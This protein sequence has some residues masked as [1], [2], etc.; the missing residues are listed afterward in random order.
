MEITNVSSLL[1]MQQDVAKSTTEVTGE[2]FK[3]ALAS[4]IENNDDKQLKASC[5]EMEAYMLSMMFKQMKECML[6]D[7]D[8]DAL[9]PKGDY[10]R[11]FESTMIDTIA[12][13]MVEAGGLG[14]SDQMYKQIKNTYGAQM[15]MSAANEQTVASTLMKI[16]KES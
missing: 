10:T 11:T 5:D 3:S 15:Q 13:K 4:A 14:L 2:D 1:S 16:D 12:E 9:I 8:E 6:S 7:D